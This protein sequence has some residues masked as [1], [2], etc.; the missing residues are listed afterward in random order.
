MKDIIEEKILRKMY[1]EE[2]KT[3]AEIAKYFNL[4]DFGLNYWM[5]KYNIRKVERWERYGLRQFTQKQIKYLYGS[6]LGDDTLKMQKKGKYPILVVC[7]SHK[8]KEYI[9]WKYKIWEKII[10][11]KIR[12]VTIRLKNKKTY[13]AFQFT[14]AV[15]PGF[16]RFH[17][18]FY[19]SKVSMLN[20]TRYK[21]NYKDNKRRVTKEIL[22]KLTPFSIAVWYMDD[23]YYRKSRGR[24][25][26][27]TNSFTY[28]ENHMI[29]KY[30]NK[31]W[32]I[33]SNI[34]TSDSGTNYIWF[35]TENTIKFF[36]IIKSYIIPY[37][38]YKID[39]NRK[40]LWQ[41][42]PLKDLQYIKANYNI[43]SPRLIANKLNRTICSIH[44][45]AFKLSVTQRRG[46]KKYYKYDL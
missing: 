22:N 10:P 4:S 32:G 12:T 2:H 18:L 7:H 19:N 20:K 35:N 33:H 17:N 1:L 23:G 11:G 40:L 6:L 13:R 46:G 15:H 14:T 37:F 30:F 44:Q 31:V 29:Q 16:Q 27:S 42:I 39:P 25:Q 43:E 24:A 3:I 9:K 41:K 45:A 8:Q 28:K 5:K 36:K 38:S 34:G 21:D 26:L